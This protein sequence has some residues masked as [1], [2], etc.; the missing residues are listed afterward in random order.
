M[1]ATGLGR[2]SERSPCLGER[3]A[4]T[5]EAYTAISEVLRVAA[6][7]PDQRKPVFEAV[8]RHATR[9]CEAKFASIY[10]REGDGFRAAAMYNAPPGFAEACAILAHPHW[11]T[12]F[13]R[14]ASTKQPA[15]ITDITQ[16][17]GYAEHHAYVE[18]AVALG[19]FRTV[20]SAPML[21]GDELT[22]IISVYRE[23]V[24]PFTE[25]QIELLTD[26]AGQAALVD[27]NVRLH[28]E[29]H[30]S[31][32]QQAA[33][34]SVLKVISH[35]TPELQ[36]VFD[37]IVRNARQLCGARFGVLHRFDGER[38]HVA[39][40]DN[41]TPEVLDVLRR[42][43]PMRPSRS[44]ASGRA[45]LT[46]AVAEIPDVQDD[47]EYQQDMA[48][49]GEWRS[50]LAV[51]ML[52]A[53]GNPIGTIVVQ[54]SEAGSFASSHI[55]LLKTFADQAVIAI[56]NVRLLNEIQEKSRQLE[57]A[58]QHKSQ[59]LANMSHE[60]RTPLNAIIGLSEMMFTNAARFGTENAIEPLKRVH[61]AG[62][63]LLSLINQVLDLSK[64]EAGKLELSPE[65]VALLPLVDEVFGTARQLAEQ[66]G[67][68][69]T[70]ETQPDLGALTVD[71]MRLRQILL[72][73]L[74]N[75]CKFTKHGQIVLR[76]SI[77]FDGG[78][79][80]EFAVADSGIGMTAEQQ[81]R[82]FEEFAQVD[83]STARR[84]GGTGLGLAISRRLARM[85]GGEVT[86]TSEVGKG[87]VFTVRLPIDTPLGS[88]KGVG[89]TDCILVVDDDA[90]ARELIADQ[91][92]AE[93]FSVVTA[94]GG[95]EGLKLARELR[96]VAMT[97]DVMMPDLDGW[98]VLA[99]LRQDAELG[100]IPVIVIT[101]V[102]EHRR[103]MTMGAAGYLTKP[104]DRTV[105]H[106][107]VG[108]FRAHAPPTRVLL[109]ED[110]RAQ[111]ERV[112]GWLAGDE[113]VVDQAASGRE[114]LF[115]LSEMK[116]DVILLDLM[117][118]EMDGFAVVAALRKEPKWR[119][120]P[121][122]IITA[123]ELDARD[124]ERLNSGV[125]SVLVK[126]T[127]RPAELVDNIR[128]LVRTAGRRNMETTP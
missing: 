6:S 86:V 118:P 83:S 18:K 45:M 32:Q 1:K 48:A 106:Q 107:L 70:V 91:L 19:R 10:L 125:Q 39:A 124:R 5:S 105:L 128:R 78:R 4:E 24:R 96:P 76:V 127:F 123:L 104:I 93:G 14:A 49:A 101:I 22:G 72:N 117:M 53:D 119:S 11:D 43:Y 74:S 26:F 35:S 81:E 17:Q 94:S 87:S 36:S 15:Q 79:W 100:E 50:L 85:M 58:S 46:Q 55:E 29:L 40:H 7:S 9:L 38:L 112:T 33:T 88:I 102:D 68:T 51:P 69:L 57:L 20:L 103:A 59:F 42:T 60:L 80:I 77:V 30:H 44:Q 111:R 95:L 75:A 115:R 71:P 113:W 67:N 47:E 12:A 61:R 25:G 116:P 2:S 62:I 114:A 92:K 28:K 90:T 122:I 27:E 109:V 98:S 120:I 54:R 34:A 110:D 89:R 84:R 41:V 73:L 31:L 97:L 8:M 21:R 64:I 16:S 108:R 3:L 37:T 63:H 82:L 52:R 65:S 23:E 56:E 99:A 66:N 121:V 13:G 126:D